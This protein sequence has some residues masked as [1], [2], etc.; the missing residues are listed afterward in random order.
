[1]L[2]SVGKEVVH[3]R[4]AD[5]P[6]L[7]PANA[8]LPWT[9]TAKPLVALLAAIAWE[10]ELF[11][12]DRPVA[13]LWAEYGAHG[14]DRVTM[15]HL[16]THTSGVWDP[17]AMDAFGSGSSADPRSNEALWARLLDAPAVADPGTVMTYSPYGAWFVLERLVATVRAEPTGVALAKLTASLGLAQLYVGRPPSVTEHDVGVGPLVT[18]EQKGFFQ[19]CSL[20]LSGMGVWTPAT[21]MLDLAMF[22]RDGVTTNGRRLIASTT[23]TAMTAIHR[24]RLQNLDSDESEF[25]YG[26]GL[27]TDPRMFGAAPS[28]RTF[29]HI[30]GQNSMLLVDPS[31]DLA[32]VVYWYGR[33]PQVDEAVRRYALTAAIYR[34]FA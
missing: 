11:D 4:V 23:M 34:E 3:L 20:P 8:I 13:D 17:P 12:I 6:D 9:C 1:V 18:P 14:K 19:F 10:E 5:G 15:R 32:A 30:G 28:A 7:P 29:G 22:F 26:L 16:L 31:R 21:S 33:A 24:V 25:H 2:I 27:I